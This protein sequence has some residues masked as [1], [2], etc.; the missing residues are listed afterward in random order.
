MEPK[1]KTYTVD[2]ARDKLENYCIY[3][4]RCHKEVR[5][6]LYT[7]RMIPAAIE[8]ITIHLIEE[9]YLN[10]ERFARS[11]ARGKF[12]SKKWGKSRIIRELRSREIS[13]PNIDLA[14][15][16]I[17]E[18][19]YLATFEALVE[20]RMGQLTSEKNKFKKKKKLADYLLYRGWPTHW[21]YEKASELIP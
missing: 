9:K 3:Q 2:E 12:K 13:K 21:I 6:K 20:K 11:F 16:E 18:E 19:D 14:L 8:Q 7:M 4:D 10:E 15:K 1:V 5:D 17:N